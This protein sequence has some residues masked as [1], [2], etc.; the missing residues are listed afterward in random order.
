MSVAHHLRLRSDHVP[1]HPVVDEPPAGLYPRPQEGVRRAAQQK[2]ALRGQGRKLRAL[3]VGGGQ[4]LFAV[5]ML[6]RQQRCLS[7]GVMLVGAGKVQDDLYLL[8]PKQLLHGIVHSGDSV[9]LPGLRRLLP[10]QVADR[11]HL[12]LPEQLRKVLEVDS[13][14]CPGSQHAYFYFGLFLSHIPSPPQ[15]IFALL[16][17]RSVVSPCSSA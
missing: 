15:Y 12:H 7:G 13:A 1:Y 9:L 5:H 10:E 3:L 4:G 6:A 17:N 11:P 8:I 16:S 2:P 14:D